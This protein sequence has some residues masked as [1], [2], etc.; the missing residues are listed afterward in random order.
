MPSWGCK[1]PGWDRDTQVNGW[2]SRSQRR[3]RGDGAVRAG[4]STG[5]TPR[6]QA[7]S[8]H[9]HTHTHTRTPWGRKSNLASALPVLWL[10]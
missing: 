10:D 5:W 2:E 6:S 1:G 7:V 3:E 4:A 9:T 8:S